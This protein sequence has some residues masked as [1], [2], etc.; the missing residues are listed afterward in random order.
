VFLKDIVLLTS[1]LT[2]PNFYI[3]CVY[4]SNTKSFQTSITNVRFFSILLIYL[5]DITN[6][7][8]IIN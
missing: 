7:A 2:L 4:I 3:F 6:V 5:E 8:D 1:Y